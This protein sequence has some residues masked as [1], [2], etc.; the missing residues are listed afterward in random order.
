MSLDLVRAAKHVRQHAGRTFV[1]KIGGA[2]LAKPRHIRRVAEQLACVHALGARLVIVHGAGPQANAAQRA[3]GEE[4]TFVDG[5][6]V[7]TPTAMQA[8]S[9]STAALSAALTE[10]LATHGATATTLNDCASATKRA[11]MQ[12]SS[13]TVDFGLVGDI[14]SVDTQAITQALETDTIPL[15]APPVPDGSGGTL[16]VNAD[17][18]AAQLATNLGASK[19][20]LLTS[21]AGI[22]ADPSDPH[23]AISVLSLAELLAQRADGSVAGGM[24]V[25]TAAIEA[26][27]A[28]GVERVHVVSGM[29]EDSLLVELYTNQG[30]G[31]LILAEGNA[32]ADAGA[33]VDADADAEEVTA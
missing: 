13:G 28:G 1:V 21:T 5:R 10:A 25:K 9:E 22:L 4:P 26:A 18:L 17:L 19:L 24:H 20:V 16:N 27:M 11:P 31:T 14:A 3:L 7:T 15:I 33:K 8:L 29:D 6:R 23:S 2:C 30:A 32:P 12:T